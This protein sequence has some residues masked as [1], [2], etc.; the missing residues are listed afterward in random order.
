MMTF[1]EYFHQAQHF[2]LAI[3]QFWT[4][5][6]LYQ[7]CALYYELPK[8]LSSL[9]FKHALAKTYPNHSGFLAVLS[10]WWRCIMAV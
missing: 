4:L 5:Q 7:F 9:V 6:Q 3:A 10:N 2:Q 1:F 8:S